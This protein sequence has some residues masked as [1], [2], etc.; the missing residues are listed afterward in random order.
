MPVPFEDPVRALLLPAAFPTTF[1]P[2]DNDGNADVDDTDLC[3][4]VTKNRVSID[5]CELCD[6]HVSFPE[7]L[8]FRLLGWYARM[9]PGS[10][11]EEVHS[12]GTVKGER[13][14]PQPHLLPPS[15]PVHRR[16]RVAAVAKKMEDMAFIASSEMYPLVDACRAAVLSTHDE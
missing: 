9:E 11:V 3:C 6:Q 12:A 5:V 16:I 15:Q 8:F 10:L 2:P 14:G 7:F 4:T 13:H 1:P